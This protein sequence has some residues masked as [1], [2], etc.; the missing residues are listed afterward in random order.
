[1]HNLLDTS[2]SALLHKD[3]VLTILLEIDRHSISCHYLTHL[4]P[5]S[6]AWIFTLWRCGTQPWRQTVYLTHW[7]KFEKCR[8]SCSLHLITVMILCNVE[9]WKSGS[10]TS[11]LSTAI[12]PQRHTIKRSCVCRLV[13]GCK[14]RCKNV[15][16]FQVKLLPLCQEFSFFLR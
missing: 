2:W 3:L 6:L 15:W 16:D 5:G 9:K 7:H 11:D 8:A 14:L 10:M 13:L 4:F 1:M 12:N